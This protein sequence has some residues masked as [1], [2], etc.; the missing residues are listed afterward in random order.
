MI[1]CLPIVYAFIVIKETCLVAEQT[2]YAGGQMCD[3][4]DSFKK[5]SLK[6]NKKLKKKEI[7]NIHEQR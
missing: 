2:Q 4:V 5:F 1:P 3:L 7:F 6:K